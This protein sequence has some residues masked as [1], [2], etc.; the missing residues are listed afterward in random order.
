MKF[1]GGFKQWISKHKLTWRWL[2]KDQAHLD[3]VIFVPNAFAKSSKMNFDFIPQT[4]TSS[5]KFIPKE[6]HD[7]L[8]N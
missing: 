2:K 5:S 1:Y 8:I 3:L 4:V 7:A 6:E